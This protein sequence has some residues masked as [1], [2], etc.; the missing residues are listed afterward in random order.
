MSNLCTARPSSIAWI[1]NMQVQQFGKHTSR[2]VQ[3]FALRSWMI[4]LQS[5]RWMVFGIRNRF[6]QSMIFISWHEK[7]RLFFWK[8]QNAHITTDNIFCYS[9]PVYGHLSWLDWHGILSTGK[10]TRWQS[11]RRS[12]I[13]IKTNV[14]V[15]VRLKPRKAIERFRWRI[16]R[17]LF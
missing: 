5:I 2:W 7:N 9:K 14:G 17:M 12:N 10:S 16:E 11:I 6:A 4:S 13:V 8:L 1:P 15:Q 3:C